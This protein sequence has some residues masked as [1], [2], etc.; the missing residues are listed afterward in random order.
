MEMRQVLASKLEELMKENNKIVILDADLS[1]PNGTSELYKKY[2]DRCFNVGIAEQNM[3]SISAGMASYGY[4]PFVF[5]FTP[6]A[7]RRACDQLTISV[8]YAKQNVKIVGTDPGLTAELNGGTHMSVED[9]GIVRSIP[10]I[11]IYDA[12]D[13]VQFGQAIPQIVRYQGPVYLRMPRKYNVAIFGEDYKFDLLK[14]DLIHEGNDVTIFATGI[15]LKE[16]LDAYQTL[17]S[18]GIN[19]EIINVHT[20]KPLDEETILKSLK[21]T[22]KAVVCENHNIIGGLFS[23]ISELTAQKFPVLMKPIGIKDRFGQVGKLTDLMKA[24]EMT[25]SDIVNT[26]KSLI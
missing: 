3:M 24:Y 17:K 11:L 12:A 25:S 10:D 16:A 21:K 6:F 7:T 20:I 13:T 9:V 8:S 1:K 2:P 18:Q 26:V 23:A 22:K 15:M 4:I 14:A 19:A 5:T